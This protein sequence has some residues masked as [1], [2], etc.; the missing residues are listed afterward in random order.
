MSDTLFS[1]VMPTY[2]TPIA[3][4]TEA[5]ESCLRQSCSRFELI[6]VDDGSPDSC[7][8]TADAY[9]KT[10]ARVRVIH[11]TNQ[12]VSAARNTGI[13]AATGDYVI[14]LD[15]DDWFAEDALE[16][17]NETIQ[18]SSSTDV[19]IFSLFRDYAD[20]S[21]P[22]Q[23]LY[24][25]PTPF[26]TQ[27]ELDSIRRDVLL[28]PLDRN[29]LVFPYCKCVRREVLCGIQPCFPVGLAMCEDVVFSLRLLLHAQSVWYLDKPMYHYRQTSQSA[30]N[31]YRKNAVQEQAMLLDEI[32]DIIGS[33]SDRQAYAQGYY[34]EAFYA[35]QRIITQHF[36]HKD[37][38]GTWIQRYRQCARLFEQAP[39]ADVLEHL[40]TSD[41]SRNHKIKAFLMKRKLYALIGWMRALFFRLPGQRHSD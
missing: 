17:L 29:I 28:K 21:V 23:P 37:A 33:V 8:E 41:L 11:Q 14:F 1:I 15:A 19:V 27:S 34:R 38:P 2:K 7:G 40:D 31:R 32:G 18:R 12:G 3:Y 30:V 4:M 13:Q 39:Y 20:A 36:F 24:P 10:D 25:S 6:V 26:A 16:Y 5:I 35:M 9:A 22:I